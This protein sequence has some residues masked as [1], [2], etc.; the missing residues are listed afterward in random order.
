MTASSSTLTLPPVCTAVSN[1]TSL[2]IPPSVG[3]AQVQSCSP[4]AGSPPPPPWMTPFN[5]PPIQQP[6]GPSNLILSFPYS[7]SF[8]SF[9]LAS[10]KSQAPQLGIQGLAGPGFTGRSHR[11]PPL[12]ARVVRGAHPPSFL[13]TSP[14]PSTY[15]SVPATPLLPGLPASALSP[16]TPSKSG[17]V[18]PFLGTRMHLESPR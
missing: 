18:P 4:P 12:L 3:P 10:D 7:K 8:H 2:S 9:P 17:P 16:S 5:L 14:T 1:V 6:G 15:P 13:T 11:L